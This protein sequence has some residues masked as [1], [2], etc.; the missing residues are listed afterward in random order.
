MASDNVETLRRLYEDVWNGADP[1]TAAELVHKS[2]R[3]HDRELAERLRGPELYRALAD[4][5][6][7]AFPDATFAIEDT[8]AAGDR[9]ALR[10]TMTG[11]HEGASFGVEPTGRRVELVGIEID[12]F[13]EGLLAESWVQSDQLGLMERVGAL[14]D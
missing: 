12:R 8:V 5:T 13:E 14:G 3:I 4:G 6:R 2:Y 7:E 10:W 1:S 9:V 11:T